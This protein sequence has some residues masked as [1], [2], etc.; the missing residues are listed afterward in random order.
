MKVV[1]AFWWQDECEL[2]ATE[3][4][5]NVKRMKKTFAPQMDGHKGEYPN[6]GSEIAWNWSSEL[7]SLAKLILK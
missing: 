3:K 5:E 7:K 1:F 2:I 6:N 4:I